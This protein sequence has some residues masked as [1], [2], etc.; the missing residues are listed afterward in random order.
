MFVV[1]ELFLATAVHSHFFLDVFFLLVPDSLDFVAA[2]GVSPLN[3]IKP[4]EGSGE[5]ID[6]SN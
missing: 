3:I 5:K 4:G 2:G 6:D 1:L